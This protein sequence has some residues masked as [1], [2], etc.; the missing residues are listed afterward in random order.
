MDRRRRHWENYLAM[1]DFLGQPIDIGAYCVYP[2][3]TRQGH[4]LLCIGKIYSLTGK[5]NLIAADYWPDHGWKVVAGGKPLAMP[6][7]TRLVVIPRERVPETALQLLER[8][9]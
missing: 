5:I 7:T 6:L 9:R 1:H 8:V 2:I 3:T 4:P